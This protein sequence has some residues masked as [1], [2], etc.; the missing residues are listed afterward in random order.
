MNNGIQNN[1]KTLSLL[2]WNFSKTSKLL[3]LSTSMVKIITTTPLHSLLTPDA[4]KIWEAMIN[5]YSGKGDERKGKK[6]CLHS[7]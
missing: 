2:N 1:A 6:F 4:N 5:S 7:P 3:L